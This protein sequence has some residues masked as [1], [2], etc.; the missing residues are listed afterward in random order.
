MLDGKAEHMAAP[1]HRKRG[2]C[3]CGNAL[4]IDQ[5]R[6]DKPLL[7]ALG[8]ALDERILSLAVERA[9]SQLHAGDAERLKRRQTIER[10]L[11]L[12][13]SDEKNLVEAIAKGEQMAPLLAK[14]KAEETRKKDLFAELAR[15]TLPA[16]AV[17]YDEPKLR[18]EIRA[19]M[20]DAKSL[21]DRQ[22]S[23]ARHILRKLVDRP[24]QFEAYEDEMGR[25]G[26]RV[27][28]QGSYLSL[29]LSLLV[30]PSVV[31]PTGFEPVL[32]A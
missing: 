23:E 16:D 25:K 32:P 26:Y 15:L 2:A 24:L 22:R 31:S 30:S 18:R 4:R 10:E 12:I 20:A 8:E 13:E 14:L 9:L 28:G 6:I 27:T 21:L 1:I 19:R 3:I 11:S 17:S 29:M 5:D 7:Q